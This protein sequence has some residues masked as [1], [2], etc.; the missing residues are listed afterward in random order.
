MCP[1]NTKNGCARCSFPI[2]DYR[3]PTPEEDGEYGKYC[4]K[5]FYDI[6]FNSVIGGKFPEGATL[7]EFRNQLLECQINACSWLRAGCLRKSSFAMEALFKQFV[8]QIEYSHTWSVRRHHNRVG[9][10]VRTSNIFV[11]GAYMLLQRKR[12]TVVNAS[13]MFTFGVFCKPIFAMLCS[14]NED[15]GRRNKRGN[16]DFRYTF[17]GS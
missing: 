6:C 3:S 4:R 17:N 16:P 1:T 11:W 7:Q 8:A 14:P 9:I 10:F 5:C 12:P 13:R 15:F 2:V